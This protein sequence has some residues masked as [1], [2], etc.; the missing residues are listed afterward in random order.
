MTLIKF[1]SFLVILSPTN[2][3]ST[4]DYL[5]NLLKTNVNQS[6][7]GVVAPADQPRLVSSF[8]NTI[9]YFEK[10]DL[11]TTTFDKW[12]NNSEFPT[13]LKSIA[14]EKLSVIKYS[15][16]DVVFLQN[17]SYNPAS[18]QYGSTILFIAGI[19]V[20]STISVSY[21]YG[22]VT[23][24]CIQQT[25]WQGCCDKMCK[26]GHCHSWFHSGCKGCSIGRGF[27]AQEIF[28]IGTSNYLQACDSIVNSIKNWS[29]V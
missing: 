12:F 10:T 26:I 19:N 15:Q 21:Y 5:Q 14:Y 29:S 20:N 22:S 16:K 6:I 7:I 3:L 18:M 9:Q 28:D 27:T 2:A 25:Y 11:T 17:I 8:S 13:A 23:A 4:N 24:Q 1:I